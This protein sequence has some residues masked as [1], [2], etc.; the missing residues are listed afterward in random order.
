M[1]S[2]AVCAESDRDTAELLAS[3]GSAS[4][5]NHN[6]IHQLLTTETL[7][8]SAPGMNPCLAAVSAHSHLASP[9]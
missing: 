1:D 4:P 5:L 8:L 9:H 3:P 7:S 2:Q 6:Q